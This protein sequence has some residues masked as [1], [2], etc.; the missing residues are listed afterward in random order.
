MHAPVL[1]R[2]DLKILVRIQQNN[3]RPLRDLADDV[4]VSAATCLRRLRRLESLSVIR[5][6]AALLDAARVGLSVTAFVEVSLVNASGVEMAAFERAMQ[7]RPEVIQCAEL[8]GE[9]DYVLTVVVQDMNAFVEFTRRHLAD[10]RL[11]RTF[12]SMLVLRQTKNEHALPLQL[13]HSSPAA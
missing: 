6:H 4:G 8:A 7:R 9:V 10:N 1:D 12:R 13:G 3:R 5:A 2:I 11:V